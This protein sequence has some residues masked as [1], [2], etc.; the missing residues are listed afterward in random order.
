MQGCCGFVGNANQQFNQAKVAPELKRFHEH[1]PGNT[2]RLLIEGIVRSKALGS[3]VLDVGAGFGGLALTLLEQGASS[4]KGP[5]GGP[6][7]SVESSALLKT[8]TGDPVVVR[9]CAGQRKTP[10]TLLSSSLGS[11]NS[12]LR[13]AQRWR[14]LLFNHRYHHRGQLVVYQRLL[15]VLVPSIYGAAADENPFAAA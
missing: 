15:D 12:W 3:T 14:P 6:A 7:T 2:T 4:A 10:H 5:R 8:P 1:G 9:G 11:V 13:R